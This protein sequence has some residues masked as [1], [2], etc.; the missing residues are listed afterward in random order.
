MKK[1]LL[2]L[3]FAA[4]ASSFSTGWQ[5]AFDR[6][7]PRAVIERGRAAEDMTYGAKAHAHEVTPFVPHV[8]HEKDKEEIL[9]NLAAKL[10]EARAFSLEDGPIMIA[11][12][13]PEEAFYDFAEANAVR[14]CTIEFKPDGDGS[15]AA[16]LVKMEGGEPHAEGNSVV[17]IQLGIYTRA[18]FGEDGVEPRLVVGGGLRNV[19]A[20]RMNPDTALRPSSDRSPRFIW[21]LD[22]HSNSPSEQAVRVRDLFTGIPTL[23]S[24]VTVKIN[25]RGTDG[26]FS[27]LCVVYRKDDNNRVHVVRAFQVGS[28]KYAI[29]KGPIRDAWDDNDNNNNNNNNNKFILDAAV[30]DGTDNG[31]RLEAC[32]FLYQDRLPEKCPDPIRNYFLV[33][34][35]QADLFH[36]EPTYVPPESPRNLILDI[37]NVMFIIDESLLPLPD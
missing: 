8:V 16:W 29:Q 31:F 19:G 11:T 15:W 1:V 17:T 25:D 14:G 23:R 2:D 7:A 33:E 20:I 30:D 3:F 6:G 24:V 4:V 10:A 37:Y 5:T 12:G 13:V 9:Q 34:I 35:P 22:H 36:G 26:R 27:G 21:E 28:A 32:S 18:L